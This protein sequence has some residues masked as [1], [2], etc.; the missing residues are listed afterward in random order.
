MLIKY[1]ANLLSHRAELLGAE[2]FIVKE[3]WP[4]S[5]LLFFFQLWR[6]SQRTEKLDAARRN[7]PT[8][9]TRGGFPREGTPS[10][11]SGRWIKPRN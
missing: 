11:E 6:L 8:R 10:A 7:A 5:Y 4:S 3:R 1:N 9:E 2:T